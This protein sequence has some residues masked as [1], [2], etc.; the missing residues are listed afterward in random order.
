MIYTI[1]F[2]YIFVDLI[3]DFSY[4]LG[5]KKY[6]IFKYFQT[7]GGGILKFSN[8]FSFFEN[9]KFELLKKSLFKTK[10]LLFYI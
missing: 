8:S 4:N 2:K 10:N 7:G 5:I 1:Y 3:R 9:K 6:E